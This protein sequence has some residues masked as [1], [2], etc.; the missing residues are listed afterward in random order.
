M[1]KIFWKQLVVLHVLGI[2][3][4]DAAGV[5]SLDT[6]SGEEKIRRIHKAKDGVLIQL[7]DTDQQT[8]GD[9]IRRIAEKFGWERVEN[10]G[11][12]KTTLEGGRL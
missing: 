6:H 10:N 9:S 12:L 1:K 5:I 2:S 7:R 4:E 11:E 8:I 3:V